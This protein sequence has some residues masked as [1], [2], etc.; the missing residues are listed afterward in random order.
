MGLNYI[1][2]WI[3]NWFWPDN[4]ALYW[5]TAYDRSDIM[6]QTF[7]DNLYDTAFGGVDLTFNDIN[8]ERPY[9]I[10]NSTSGTSDNFGESFTFTHDD[11]VKLGS[12]ISQYHVSRAVMASASFPAV[13]NYMTLYN[14]NNDGKGDKYLHVFDGGNVDNLGLDSARKIIELPENDK[15]KKIVVLLVDAFTKPKGVPNNKYDALSGVD[16]AVDFNFLD[17]TDS[18]LNKVRKESLDS[19]QKLVTTLE[20]QDKKAIFFHLSFNEVSHFKNATATVKE[21]DLENEEAIIR[22]KPL[23]EVLN[24]ISTNFNISDDNKN[25][26]AKAV[27]LLVTSENDCIKKIKALINNDGFESND[28]HC[29]WPQQDMSF[30]K[31]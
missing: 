21:H 22:E 2:R 20:T 9:I 1:A 3:A 11:F 16:Y 6:A 31:K 4:I 25:A 24:N 28:P 19:I 30:A 15:Y 18:L 8:E 29:M 7:A 27:S 23:K 17:S 5:A 10:I 13:F 12:D 26:I 14:Y